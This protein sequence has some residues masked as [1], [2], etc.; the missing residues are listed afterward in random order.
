M[1][2]PMDNMSDLV[3]ATLLFVLVAVALV[4]G[5]LYFGTI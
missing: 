1:V 3:E 2:A 5:Q 4:V